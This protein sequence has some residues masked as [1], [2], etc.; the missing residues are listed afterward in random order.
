MN[1]PF[2]LPPLTP[3]GCVPQWVGNGFRVGEQLARVLVYSSNSS[4]W[5]DDLTALHEDAAGPNH[6]IDR[7]SRQHALEV[8]RKNVRQ[9]RPVILEVGCSSGFMLRLIREQFPNAA[10]MGSDVVQGPLDRLANSLP[11]VPLFHFDLVNCPLPD[12]SIDA[13]VLL[14]VLEHIED[15]TA[16]VKQV[17]RIL[18]PGGIAVI[19][20]PAGPGL[21]DAYDKALMHYRRYRL[22]ALRGIVK[23]A[24]FEVVEQSHLGF[25]LYP[26]FWLVKQRNKRFL[27]QEPAAHRQV[28]QQNIHT[29]AGRRLPGFFMRV[30]LILGRWISYPFGIRC[31]LSCGK[32]VE[33]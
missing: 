20:V 7:A 8:L 31:L 4:G 26:A 12:N 22:S 2:E 10:V 13:V 21:Y 30:E 6:F 23:K 15:D 24:N 25:F 3:G 28:V 14:N 17:Y 16:A 18:R 11:N 19:E 29:T 5:T 33:V 1:V 27:S 32:A 9:E